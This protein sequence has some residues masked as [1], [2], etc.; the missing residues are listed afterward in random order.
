[1]LLAI[2]VLLSAGI[3]LYIKW[4]NRLP[5]FLGGEEPAMK[6]ADFDQ[7]SPSEQFGA[8]DYAPGLPSSVLAK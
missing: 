5:A 2:P 3:I 8:R 7:P 1:M 6:N 4:G